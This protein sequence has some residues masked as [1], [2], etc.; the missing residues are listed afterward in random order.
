MNSYFERVIF[1][2]AF[3]LLALALRHRSSIWRSIRFFRS[4]SWPSVEAT[5]RSPEVKSWDSSKGSTYQPRLTYSYSFEGEEHSGSFR[6]NIYG[7]REEAQLVLS[8]LCSMS[9]VMVRV[10][11]ARPGISVVTSPN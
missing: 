8:Q 6:G 3:V 11:P 5:I 2:A 10:N 7:S 1:F 9:P 4:D